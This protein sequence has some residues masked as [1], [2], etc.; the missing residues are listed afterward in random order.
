MEIFDDE[1]KKK[2]V[3][4]TEPQQGAVRV[5]VAL[6]GFIA[7]NQNSD[8]GVETDKNPITLRRKACGDA[9][10]ITCDGPNIFRLKDS[11]GLQ[12]QVPVQP[13][14][15]PYV[16]RAITLSELDRHIIAWLKK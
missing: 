8:I 7:D 3:G 2:I 15:S 14:P 12:R 13:R 11:I 9:L 4:E 16:A 10:E 1:Q 6:L 5:S